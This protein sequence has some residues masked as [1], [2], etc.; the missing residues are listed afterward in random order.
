MGTTNIPLP[1]RGGGGVTEITQTATVEPPDQFY[2][3]EMVLM[4]G[5]RISKEEVKRFYD[6]YGKTLSID[7][8]WSYVGKDYNKQIEY[9]KD[10]DDDG[11]YY[12][13]HT[14]Y[15]GRVQNSK[16]GVTA[17]GKDIF[18]NKLYNVEWEAREDSLFPGELQTRTQE[19]YPENIV[20]MS[21]MTVVTPREILDDTLK[22]CINKNID[23]H[24]VATNNPASTIDEF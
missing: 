22:W 12:M 18:Q 6:L 7:V 24:N 20:S 19:H 14:K 3:G 17:T 1:H 8:W 23:W 5:K 13:V 4:R 9:C 2:H 15:I 10:I 21:K 16:L 11:G